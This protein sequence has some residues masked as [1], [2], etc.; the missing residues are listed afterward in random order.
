MPTYNYKYFIHSLISSVI[1]ICIW[2]TS[3][4]LNLQSC[5]SPASSPASSYSLIL[6][7]C[8]IS[9][10]MC[11]NLPLLCHPMSNQPILKTLFIPRQADPLCTPTTCKSHSNILH[12]KLIIDP[13]IHSRNIRSSLLGNAHPSKHES[14]QL[15]E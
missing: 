15:R 4:L 2:N 5:N 11:H 7:L 9:I 14:R 1:S 10:N 8:T 6:S 13:S 12:F 3:Q